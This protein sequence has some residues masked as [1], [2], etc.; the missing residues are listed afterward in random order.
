VDAEWFR[1]YRS[2]NTLESSSS[3][4]GY[5]GPGPVVGGPFILFSLAL[6][7]T[8]LDRVLICGHALF[9]REGVSYSLRS[10]ILSQLTFVASALQRTCFGKD[11]HSY[12]LIFGLLTLAFL[13]YKVQW[14]LT[15]SQIYIYIYIYI[16][17]YICISKWLQSR[18]LESNICS[19]WGGAHSSLVVSKACFPLPLSADGCAVAGVLSSASTGAWSFQNPAPKGTAEAHAVLP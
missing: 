15:C 4:I 7:R 14:A 9:R 12:V 18:Q 11:S 16:Y 3:I 1:W 8:F 13:S 6:S 17:L 5:G 2:T 10:A 19:V